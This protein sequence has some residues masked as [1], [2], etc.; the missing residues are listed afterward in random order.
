MYGLVIGIGYSRPLVV[1]RSW[2]GARSEVLVMQ[3]VDRTVLFVSPHFPPTNAPDMQRVRLLLPYLHEQGWKPVVLAVEPGQV[4]APLDHWLTD[5]LPTDAPVHRVTA[6]GLGWGRVPGLGTLT[7]RALGAL[8]HTGDALLKTGRFD[9][10]YF[11]TTQFGLHTLGPR[12]QRRFGVPFV[13]DYQD[14]W[15]NDYYR[16]HP[17]ATPPGGRL[18][19]AIADRLNRRMEPRVLRHCAGVTSVSVAYPEQLR[20]RYD[21]LPPDWP[22]EVLPFPGDDRDLRR[23][24]ID[25]TQQSV[26]TPGHGHRH[27]VYVGRGGPDMHLALR[28]LFGALREHEGSHPG[29]LKALCLHFVGT[30]Y[31]AAGRGL[32]TIE[33]LAAEYGLAAIVREYPDRI[34]YSQTLRCLLDADALIVPGSDD[35]AYTASKIYPYLL[36]GKPLLAVFHE[37]SSVVSL[38]RTVGGGVCVPFQTDEPTHAL[39]HRIESEW[40][41][42][43]DWQQ[44]VP[45]DRAAFKP[46]TAEAQANV[47][48]RFF[49]RCLAAKRAH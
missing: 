19:Y 8:R 11:S 24:E 23:V 10:V 18:K 48:C 33:P 2:R 26:F 37:A 49:D 44:P 28:G 22:V 17:E 40:L 46:H 5:G 38:I 29:F 25:G 41:E 3:G 31:A 45:L 1:R 42:S 15:V 13:M 36:A 34:P 30:S 6:L 4:A 32:K 7:F 47:L 20:Q 27:W 43:G 35:P 39:S 9:L 12:W 14:P 16:K 21:F